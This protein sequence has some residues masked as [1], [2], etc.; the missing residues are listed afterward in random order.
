MRG[1]PRCSVCPRGYSTSPYAVIKRLTEEE[2]WEDK[3]HD[4][5]QILLKNIWPTGRKKLYYLF[6]FGDNW[7]FEIRKARG[8][9][10]LEMG[11]K[12]PRL[13]KVI[14][15]NPVQHLGFEE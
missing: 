3:E 12:Y 5:F 11:V 4:F 2:K 9:K 13:I 8:R 7:V 10:E 6:D 15:P 1:T 14:G